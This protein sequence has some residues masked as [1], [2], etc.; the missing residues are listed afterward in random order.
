ME[1]KT[2]ES[3]S[4][5]TEMDQEEFF[6]YIENE[7]IK[8]IEEMLASP[9]EIW[10]Y[11]SKEND[12]STVLHISV[13]KKLYN[14][15]EKFINHCKKYNPQ[16]L[17]KFINKKNDQGVSPLHYASFRGN[18]KII[19]LLIE[20]GA[21]IYIKTKRNLNVIHYSCQGNKPNS[22][23]F[24]YLELLQKKDYNLIKEQDSGGSSPLHW[25]AYSSAEDVLL[26]LINLDI[27]KNKEEKQSFIDK[28]DKHGYTPLHLSVISKSKRI[29]MKLLQNGATSDI[30]DNKGLTPLNLAI[31]KKLR[32][33]TQILKNNQKCQICN[34]KAPVKQIK[35]SIK[36]IIFVFFFQILTTLILFI[37]ILPIAFN[38]ENNIFYSI[39]F[40]IYIIS[41][42]L[43]FILY[44][45]LLLKDPGVMKSKTLVEIS[46]IINNEK[47]DLTKYCYKCFIP[48]TRTS[49]HCIICDKCYEDFDHHCYWINKCVAEKNYNLFL[50]FLFETFIYLSIILSIS[51]LGLIQY[52]KNE[53]KTDFKLIFKFFNTE[54]LKND[55]L[56]SNHIFHLI[57]I[58]LQIFIDLFFLIPEFLL[59]ILHIGVCIENRKIKKNKINSRTSSNME[60]R[61]LSESSMNSLSNN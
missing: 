43:F 33:I 56:I 53:N 51:I 5:L 49:K 39:F 10:N 28:K 45:S 3:E 1:E 8:K 58:I 44:I 25:A 29:V 11:I 18:V 20:N 52:L 27:F 24:F 9:N 34:F 17:K 59:L 4:S 19:K 22:L 32:E 42:I 21:D 12:N 54:L 41:L 38:D 2:Y 36:N 14:I 7:N 6:D 47:E 48:K 37:S 13:Y 57:L 31:N 16:G 61:L 23:M 40:I 46:E 35:K 60:N 50:F 15:T 55:I 30:K 26:Y